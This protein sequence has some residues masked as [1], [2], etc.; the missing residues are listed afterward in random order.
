V[1]PPPKI[2]PGKKFDEVIEKVLGEAKCMVVLWSQESIRRDW[3]KEE[4]NVGKQRGILLPAKIEQVNPPLGFGLIQAA[5][6]TDW[7]PHQSHD[8]FS[9]LVEAITDL[10]GV[11]E[12]KKTDQAQA[13]KSEPIVLPKAKPKRALVPP[14]TI[15]T[16]PES[17]HRKALASPKSILG[18]PKE[19]TKPI[20]LPKAML[21][22]ALVPPSKIQTAPESVLTNSIGMKFVL[23]PAGSFTVG[24]RMSPKEIVEVYG[25]QEGWYNREKPYHSVKIERSFYLQTTNVTQGQWQQIMRSN[26]SHFKDCGNDCPVEQGSWEDAQQFIEKLNQAEKTRSYRL[27]SEA[28]WE[29]A[30]RAGSETE[31]FFGD[32]AKG[33]GEFA[34]FDSNSGG[35]THPVG[36]WKPNAWGLYDMHGNV[37]EWVED[38]WHGSYEGAPA[39]GRTWVDNPRGSDRVIRGGGWFIVARY[40]RSAARNRDA[41]VDRDDYVGFR[42]SRF[43]SLGP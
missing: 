1:G 38:D 19:K 35:K 9:A 6:L 5:D 8:G 2:P 4:A 29:Y 22:R 11:P 30:C 10:A 15:Q 17:V 32:D 20:V 14:S 24:S 37:W 18:P 40:C 36:K 42:L 26:P 25:G 13:I 16:A 7:T 21:K 28:E 41:P 43:V 34:W 31:F 39:D 3:V 23:I 12:A 27:A 33:L